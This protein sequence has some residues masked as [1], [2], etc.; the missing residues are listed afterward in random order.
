MLKP[1]EQMKILSS[2]I[3][4]GSVALIPLN[5]IHGLVIEPEVV[6]DLMDHDVTDEISHFLGI[7]AVLFN[8]PLVDVDGVGQDIA[9]GGVPA[10][11]VDAPVEAVEGVRRL[12]PH[13]GQGLVVRPVLD[14]D[15]DIGQLVAEG[16]GQLAEGRIDERFEL[17]AGHHMTGGMAGDGWRL[18]AGY[19]PRT[20]S[21][22]A[23][24]LTSRMA[25][26]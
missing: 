20:R 18:L 1:Y 26:M 23:M 15:G 25:C 11:D 8:R 17:P 4:Q 21:T 10:G 6:A 2:K 19:T 3:R 16:T 14:H 9:V 12:D 7:R 13:F 24:S 5:F 22:L